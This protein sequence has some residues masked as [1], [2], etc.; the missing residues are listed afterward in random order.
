MLKN[1]TRPFAKGAPDLM[2]DANYIN[3]TRCT[4]LVRSA[5]YYR[6]HC[7]RVAQ[8]DYETFILQ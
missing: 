8:N 1:R 3:E 6:A 2:A 7:D 5:A 4:E